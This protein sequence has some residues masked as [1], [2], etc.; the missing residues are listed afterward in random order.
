[1]TAFVKD[2][3]INLI[4]MVTTL[5]SIVDYCLLKLQWVHEGAC[6]GH[7]V[8]K[9]YQCDINDEKVIVGLKHVNLKVGQGSLQKNHM[10]EDWE[11]KGKTRK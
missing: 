11:K 6:F 3:G 4:S 7:I 2:E 5:G 1:M 10:D 8:F 9:A